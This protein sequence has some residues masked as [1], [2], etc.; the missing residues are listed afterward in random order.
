MSIDIRWHRMF[1]GNIRQT[2]TC[3]WRRSDWTIS[4]LFSDKENYTFIILA[5]RD[6]FIKRLLTQK[7]KFCHNLLKPAWLSFF[8]ETQMWTFAGRFLCSFHNKLK[9]N[10]S[11]LKRKH[12]KNIKSTIKSSS[13][14]HCKSFHFCE[15]YHFC[16]QD[17][18]I[19]ELKRRIN[20]QSDPCL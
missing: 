14:N 10:S 8:S 2:L 18:F 13:V 1:S 3:C 19:K 17:Q 16:E 9:P 4:C 12:K 6:H 20:L 5:D 11:Y 15:T 7:S